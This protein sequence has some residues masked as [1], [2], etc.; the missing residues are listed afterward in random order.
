M[1]ILFTYCV[2]DFTPLMYACESGNDEC[3]SVLIDAGATVLTKVSVKL[4]S[5]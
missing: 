1:S 5:G 3:L 2:V 4:F